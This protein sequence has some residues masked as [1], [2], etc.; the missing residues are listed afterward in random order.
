M[1]LLKSFFYSFIHFVSHPRKHVFTKISQK[2]KAQHFVMVQKLESLRVFRQMGMQSVWACFW[3]CCHWNK[4]GAPW[5]LG[6]LFLVFC[7]YWRNKF[8][9][10]RFVFVVGGASTPPCCWLAHVCAV[11]FKIK[12]TLNTMLA[13]VAAAVRHRGIL[14]WGGPLFQRVQTRANQKHFNNN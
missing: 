5:L 13:V 3:L 10:Q 11:L 6:D 2:V 4:E 14:C 1:S 9:C 12:V 7:S 8:T